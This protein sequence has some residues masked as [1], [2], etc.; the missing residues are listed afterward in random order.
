SHSLRRRLTQCSRG[1]VEGPLAVLGPKKSGLGTEQQ[2]TLMV[3]RT[4]AD[5][6]LSYLPP[7]AVGI[8]FCDSISPRTL[9]AAV[10]P[11][12]GPERSHTCTSYQTHSFSALALLRNRRRWHWSSAPRRPQRTHFGSK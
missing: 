6:Q 2:L 7:A 3:R 12:A 10:R 9:A 4:D 1:S 11:S 5:C 8:S